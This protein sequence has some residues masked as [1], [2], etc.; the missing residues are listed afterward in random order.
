MT[1]PIFYKAPRRA[2]GSATVTTARPWRFAWVV[3]ALLGLSC[4][5]GRV[6]AGAAPETGADSPPAP[7]GSSGEPGRG[8][9]G[10]GSTPA[11]NGTSAGTEGVSPPAWPRTPPVRPLAAGAP[12]VRTVAKASLAAVGDVLMHGAVKD[13]AQ[14]H[15]SPGDEGGF[16]WLWSPIADLL[17]GADLTFANLETPVAPRSGQGSR[18]FVFNAPPALVSALKRAGVDLVSVANNHV[19]DQG[20][21][22]FEET[23]AHLGALGMAYVGGG[24]AGREA[25][26]RLVEVNGLRLAFLGYSYGFNQAGNDCPPATGARPCLRA[27]V[28]DGDRATADVR[29]A[30]AQAD[31]VI[32]SVH[33][34]VEYTGQPREAEVALARRLADAGAL[35]VLG[36]HPHV[37]QPIE[38]HA[39][40]DGR[41]AL[42]AYSL[43][44]FVSNQSR[45]YVHGVTPENV[46]ATRDGVIL[47]VEIARRDYG[48]GV[49]R[50]ELG[51]AGFLPLWTENDTA[52]PARR[53][54]PAIRVVALDRAL[55]D[56][57]RDLAAL[58]DP[59][60]PPEQA[61]YLR[62]RQRE[63]LY[64][65]RRAAIAAVLGDDLA[66]EAPPAPA[67]PLPPARASA[68]PA[69]VM[70]H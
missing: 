6:G 20:R 43:G 41:M 11:T 42:I 70:P 37:L 31:A 50:V 59:L 46:G 4:A 18:S 63:E 9:P 16:G 23:L 8:E 61:R 36:H 58:P 13:A 57:R 53:A 40:P 45:N 52:D 27:S 47:K 24:E 65:S 56:V 60:P 67:P 15:R 25:G 48:R 44:N 62:L 29:S 21:A 10:A 49:S 54:R 3:A 64:R 68:A 7:S 39:T 17:A 35:V 2:V 38:L 26:P 19:F 28:L 1:D 66:L 30:A 51:G 22:G 12:P 14:D 33:W 69:P 34:G 5:T 32:V 55:A